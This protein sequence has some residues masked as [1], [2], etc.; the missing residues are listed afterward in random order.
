MNEQRDPA[1]VVTPAESAPLPVNR[2]RGATMAVLIGPQTANPRFMTR[3]FVLDPGGRIPAHR[4]DSIEHHQ[5]V[6]RGEMELSLDGAERTVRA[7]DAVLIPAAC[8]HSYQNRSVEPCEF[9]CIVPA[10]S[11]YQ[12]EWLEDPPQGAY[13]K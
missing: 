11:E 1:V 4:H 10:T 7:G 5:V 13:L 8:A 3:R 9:I 2:A 12:T 6:V